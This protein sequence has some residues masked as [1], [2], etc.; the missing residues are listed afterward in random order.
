MHSKLRPTGW[1]RFDV[2][3]PFRLA[4]AQHRPVIDS[5]R[6]VRTVAAAGLALVLAVVLLSAAIRLGQA[7]AP[8]L[9]EGMLLMLR[10]LHRAA[11]SLEVLAAAWLAWFAWRVR[12]ERPALARGVALASAI[13]VALSVLGIVAGRTPAPAAAAG[14]LL[15]GLALAA[16]FAWI[17]GVLRQPARRVADY[18]VAGGAV[19]LAVQCLLG[20][21]LAV[22]PDAAASPALPAHAMLGVVL[23]CGA[24]WLSRGI[25]H[26]RQRAAGF[27][28]ALLVPLAGFTA[29]HFEH[30]AVAAFAHASVAALLIAAA[31]YTR[32]RPA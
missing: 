4:R 17:L 14:N 10:T 31:A 6:R 21:R 20:T 26:A 5:E 16:V 8:P 28:L 15:G 9:G 18:V 1:C 29:L 19:L 27:A 22:F 11:A 23:A 7:A 13:T 3:Q 32:F 30:S 2:Y 25:G 12:A 24:A